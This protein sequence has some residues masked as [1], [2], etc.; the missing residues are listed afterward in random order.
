ML[1]NAFKIAVNCIN[2][3]KFLKVDP[4]Y[5]PPSEKEFPLTRKI[6]IP[7]MIMS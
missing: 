4:I 6:N 7:D 3:I 2:F 5:P 1:D